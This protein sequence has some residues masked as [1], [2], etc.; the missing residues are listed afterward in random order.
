MAHKILVLFSTVDG[1]IYGQISR[2]GAWGEIWSGQ[3]AASGKV[4]TGVP[5][6]VL[7]GDRAKVEYEAGGEARSI[8]GE[9]KAK[10]SNTAEIDLFSDLPEVQAS[11]YVDRW[12]AGYTW[13]SAD[14]AALLAA[15]KAELGVDTVD[16]MVVISDF[17][18][19]DM[20]KWK[21]DPVAKQ[22]VAIGFEY[23]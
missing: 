10:V 14:R 18:T 2:N 6:S 9:V 8:M 7:E 3:V 13:D 21:V 22:L 4:L 17:P 15:K 5:V 19:I 23:E 20:R 12:T 16:E 11:A 1:E